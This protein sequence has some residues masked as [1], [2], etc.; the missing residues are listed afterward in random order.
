[1]LLA[2]G[3]A[4]QEPAS[5][6]LSGWGPEGPRLRYEAALAQA[7]AEPGAVRTKSG[8]VYRDL[9]AGDGATPQAAQTVT[10]RFR[11]FAPDGTLLRDSAAEYGRDVVVVLG[12]LRDCEHEVLASLRARG[13]RRF[14]C[15]PSAG[16]AGAPAPEPRFVEVTLVDVGAP[17]PVKGH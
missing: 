1:V 14:L 12:Q 13:T 11:A 9:A 4:T 10:L 16:E 7:L 15:P 8:L 3:C 2:A 6:H 5:V 17:L